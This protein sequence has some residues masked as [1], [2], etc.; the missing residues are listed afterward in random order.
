[1]HQLHKRL[2]GTQSRGILIDLN[3]TSSTICMACSQPLVMN[4]TSETVPSTTSNQDRK[5]SESALNNNDS[6]FKL[7]RTTDQA[8]RGCLAVFRCRH[9][10]HQSCL[11]SI[12]NS[13]DKC[14]VCS[15]SR[16]TTWFNIFY[17]NIPKLYRIINEMWFLSFNFITQKIYFINLK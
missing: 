6:C 13:T 7:T 2:L 16:I 14:P 12:K 10:F 8:S 15:K 1:M 17:K 4:V 9:I 3:N 11:L 5:F